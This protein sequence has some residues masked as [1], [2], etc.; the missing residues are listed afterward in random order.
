MSAG[1][2]PSPPG[3]RA[4]P[5]DHVTTDLFVRQRRHVELVGTE[6]ESDQDVVCPGLHEEP[7]HAHDEQILVIDHLGM[8]DPDPLGSVGVV[9]GRLDG[10]ARRPGDGDVA[11]V[12]RSA[13]QTRVASSAAGDERVDPF[14]L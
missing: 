6:T 14:Q 13:L 10:D 11:S 2:R 8:L 12:D 7:T 3:C 9:F 4:S 1:S 5:T